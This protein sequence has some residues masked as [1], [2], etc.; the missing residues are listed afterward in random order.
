MDEIL[1][2]DPLTQKILDMKKEQARLKK[3]KQELRRQLKNAVSRRSRLKKKARQLPDEDLVH[4]L[5]WRKEAKEKKNVEEETD[6]EPENL[7]K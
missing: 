1:V 7:V 4:V 2:E 5:M 3:E 6:P